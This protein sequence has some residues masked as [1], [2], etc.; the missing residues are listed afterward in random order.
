MRNLPSLLQTIVD[1]DML[2]RLYAVSGIVRGEK[3]FEI[4]YK[5]DV[6]TL[7]FQWAWARIMRTNSLDIF[8]ACA[9]AGLNGRPSWIPDLRKTWGTDRAL[10]CRI[11]NIPAAQQCEKLE[12]PIGNQSILIEMDGNNRRLIV[13]GIDVVDRIIKI[14]PVGDVTR[15][16]DDPTN[17][18]N[19]LL[20]AISDW[21]EMCISACKELYGESGPLSDDPASVTSSGAFGP[22]LKP[23]RAIKFATALLRGYKKWNDEEHPASLAERFQV[24]RWNLPVRYPIV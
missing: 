16:M 21:E 22:F 12:D 20:A 13:K 3:D 11:H 6:E 4:D 24:W 23:E 8:S 15:N 7:Y 1:T 17:L 14:G 19:G 5:I 18:R 10:F 9:D 2:S